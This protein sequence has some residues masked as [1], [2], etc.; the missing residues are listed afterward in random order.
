MC[1]LSPNLSRLVLKS[2]R[3][4]YLWASRELPSGPTNSLTEEHFL[5]L[6]ARDIDYVDI[7]PFVGRIWTNSRHRRV[8]GDEISL[9]LWH[10]PAEKDRGF[11]KLY[12]TA[13]DDVFR[14]RAGRIMGF[15]DE[16]PFDF[17]RTASVLYLRNF[18]QTLILKMTSSLTPVIH[19]WLLQHGNVSSTGNTSARCPQDAYTPRPSVGSHHAFCQPPATYQQSAPGCDAF[20]SYRC[21]PHP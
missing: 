7:S 18:E 2:L 16:R 11:L 3:V 10:L 14:S 17:Q 8:C 9:S 13:K 6:L 21:P 20:S 12:E 15:G 1:Y 5:T 19:A 4:L